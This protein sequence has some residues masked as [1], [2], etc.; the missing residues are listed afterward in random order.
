ME[1]MGLILIGL[2]TIMI[3]AIILMIVIIIKLSGRNDRTGMSDLRK[4]MRYEISKSRQET[5]DSVQSS[6]KNL[7][8]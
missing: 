5:L 4:E 1:N 8:I 3:I 2:F 6:I 7:G